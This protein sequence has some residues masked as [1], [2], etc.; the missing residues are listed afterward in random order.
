[1]VLYGLKI[2]SIMDR[3]QERLSIDNLAR[4]LVDIH[5]DSSKIMDSLISTCVQFLSTAAAAAASAAL[6]KGQ[7][8]SPARFPTIYARTQNAPL[9]PCRYQRNLMAV[10]CCN[11]EKNRNKF[12][13]ILADAI[14]PKLPAAQYLDGEDF[15]NEL[16]QVLGT[17]QSVYD[18]DEDTVLLCGANGT[19]IAGTNAKFYEPSILAYLSLMSLQIFVTQ[20]FAR[21]FMVSDDLQ[22]IRELILDYQ[23]R[24][25]SVWP[26]LWGMP[27]ARY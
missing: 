15:E 16:K 12:N 5:E 17:I 6:S 3:V 23:V 22:R 9:S 2:E 1:M 14:E 10:T 4:V 20:F 13:V 8:P 11:D 25:S 24:T 21:V 19:L 7:F 26:W 27:S 18:L